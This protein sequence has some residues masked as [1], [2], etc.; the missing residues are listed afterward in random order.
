M[1]ESRTTQYFGTA[2]ACIL[3]IFALPVIFIIG[4]VCQVWEAFHL[5]ENH[6]HRKVG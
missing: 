3:L 4:G 6:E 5:K 2:V 1:T